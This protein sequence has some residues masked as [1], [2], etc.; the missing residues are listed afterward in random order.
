MLSGSFVP[1]DLAIYQYGSSMM[2]WP[3]DGLGRF[4]AGIKPLTNVI[5]FVIAVIDNHGY[6]VITNDRGVWWCP[7]DALINDQFIL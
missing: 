2:S 4:T 6:I 7:A 3:P 5:V 1:G